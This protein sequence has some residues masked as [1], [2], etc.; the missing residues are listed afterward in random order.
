MKRTSSPIPSLLLPLSV[1]AVLGACVEPVDTGDGVADECVVGGVTLREAAEA[2][3]LTPYPCITGSL[4]VDTEELT[5][6][7]LPNL[8]AIG[9]SLYV[10]GTGEPEENPWLTKID[11]PALTSIGG[12]LHIH[13]NRLLAELN[14]PVLEN[15]G[16][17]PDL[18]DAPNDGLEILD[19][20]SLTVLDLPALARVGS[21][22]APADLEISDH[23]G[24]TAIHLPA[25][26]TVWGD[27]T[28]S[29][30]DELDELDTPALAT[31]GGVVRI[32]SNPALSSLDGLAAL[33]SAGGLQLFDLPALPVVTLPALT[34]AYGRIDLRPGPAVRIVAMPALT[35]TDGLR[36][37]SW[38]DR[39]DDGAV[40]LIGLG[41]LTTVNG[42]LTVQGQRDL[43]MLPLPHL[44]T[45]TGSLLV[46]ENGAITRLDGLS[47]LTTVGGDLYVVENPMLPYCEIVALADQLVDFTGQL[48]MRGNLRD[49]CGWSHGW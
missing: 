46:H 13:E 35:V 40:V 2:T 31:V 22:F 7:E 37:G 6:L 23:Q 14:L 43:P 21:A 27:V 26:E 28:L 5:H 41:A 38:Q 25:L 12:G 16:T 20:R 42:D 30:L 34:E 19:N 33:T 39:Y 48:T 45:I 49:E 18:A 4:V 3:A 11:L 24:L 44:T 9:G 15:V 17:Q 47:A 32:E 29:H 10:G 8:Q 1:L 36:F